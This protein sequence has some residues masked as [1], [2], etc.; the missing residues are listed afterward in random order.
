MTY[1]VH[2]FA[3]YSEERNLCVITVTYWSNV[4]YYHKDEF[5]GLQLR[6]NIFKLFISVLD[7]KSQ[8]IPEVVVVRRGAGGV[9]RIWGGG[10][11]G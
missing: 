4:Q 7:T 1:G 6:S 9:L 11:T 10:S 8:N 2:I 5:L 3:E